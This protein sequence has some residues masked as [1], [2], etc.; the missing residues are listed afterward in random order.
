M[1]MRL[2]RLLVGLLRPMSFYNWIE[3]PGHE[4][5]R[6]R[7]YYLFGYIISHTLS[8]TYECFTLY[9]DGVPKWRGARGGNDDG[10]S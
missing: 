4:A 5:A 8:R 3:K 10:K 7:S 1:R 9:R 2:L 6:W